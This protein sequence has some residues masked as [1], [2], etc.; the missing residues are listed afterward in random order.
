MSLFNYL[1]HVKKLMISSFVRIGLNLNL[2]EQSKSEI[3]LLLLEEN[4][5]NVLVNLT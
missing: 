3:T 2:L 4:V 1:H 5:I